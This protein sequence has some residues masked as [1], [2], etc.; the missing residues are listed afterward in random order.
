MTAVDVA[1]VSDILPGAMK[2]VQVRG[3]SILLANVDGKI[4]AVGDRCGHMNAPLAMGTL[5][6]N[7]VKCPMHNAVFDVTTGEVLGQPQMH[8]PAGADKLPP[9]F[10]QAMAKMGEIMQRIETLPLKTYRVSVEG[11]RVKVDI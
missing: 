3:E 10:L 2:K 1:A 11:G 9:E 7:A 6:K 5:K 4:H 8:A